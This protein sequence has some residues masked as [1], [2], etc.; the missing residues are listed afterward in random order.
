MPATN[1]GNSAMFLS[2]FGLMAD[3]FDFEIINM[4]R[5]ILNAELG[6]MHHHTDAMI[7]ASAICGAIMGQLFFGALADHIGRRLL[8]ITTISLVGLASLAS[9]LAPAEGA[10]GMSVYTI[11]AFWRFVMGF[12]IGG[13]YPLAAASTVENSSAENS[14]WALAV[15]FSGMAFGI[16]L[17]P[18]V[19]LIMSGP[20]AMPHALIWRVAFGIGAVLAGLCAVL[21]Y[22]LLPE[23]AV[24]KED[25]TEAPTAVQARPRRPSVQA[26]VGGKMKALWTMRVSLAGTAGSWFFYDICTYGV[27]LFTT[28][29]FPAAP[30]LESAKMVLFI[31]V[32]ALPGYVGAIWLSSV[33]RM[34]RVMMFGLAAM[35]LCF[36]TLVQLDSERGTPIGANA[37]L[38]IFALAR[39]FDGMGPGVATF[40]IPGQI[41]P[42][43]IRTTA[44]GI[45]A[46]V[47]KVGAVIGTFTFPHIL[48]T[49]GHQTGMAFMAAECAFTLAW[50]MFFVPSYGPGELGEIAKLDF[51]TS[52]EEQAFV[53]QRL[54]FSDAASPDEALCLINSTSKDK[55]LA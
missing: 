9:A 44:H 7:T 20:L 43:R 27:G 26:A 1:H 25:T 34:K 51:G 23:T 3:I 39:M 29:I 16:I 28:S 36:F 49:M 6:V 48:S 32:I 13:E 53:A 19:I 21:R 30:G 47:G 37:Y 35:S 54:L 52:I 45:S 41:Y 17:C 22:L 12:G 42:T 55:S 40:S 2:A 14:G 8:F 31:N 33:W 10:F 18:V 4:V 24:F 46:A 15:S 11:I 50:T 5:P 38:T